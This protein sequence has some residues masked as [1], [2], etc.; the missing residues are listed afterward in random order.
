M[1]RA[2]GK[3]QSVLRREA[4]RTSKEDE[5]RAPVLHRPRVIFSHQS[6]IFS[7]QSFVLS[8]QSLLLS[9]FSQSQQFQASCKFLGLWFGILCPASCSK[10][11]QASWRLCFLFQSDYESALV[12]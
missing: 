2:E 8:H 4:I 1:G 3:V 7:K 5:R 6:F 11:P 12:A 10:K 9:H